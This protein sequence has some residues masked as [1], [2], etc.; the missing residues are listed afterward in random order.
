MPIGGWI[1]FE[2]FV[3]CIIC[4]AGAGVFCLDS[5]FYKALLIVI[6]IIIIIGMLLYML[7]WFN[8]TVSGQ[9]ALTDQEREF[10]NDLGRVARV[11]TANGFGFW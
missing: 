7:W 10:A 8:S 5:T 2:S 4:V 1:V 3:V 9:R 11:Y 6:S